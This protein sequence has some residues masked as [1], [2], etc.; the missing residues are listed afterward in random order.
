MTGGGKAV[1]FSGKATVEQD[2]R[3]QPVERDLRPQG[4]LETVDRGQIEAD[5]PCADHKRRHAEMEPVEGAGRQE[6][7]EGLRLVSPH[8]DARVE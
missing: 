6:G 7:R 2:I 5:G 8:G 1:L 4:R 3:A